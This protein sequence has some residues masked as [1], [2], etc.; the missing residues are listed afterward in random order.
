MKTAAEILDILIKRHC[1]AGVC[2]SCLQGPRKATTPWGQ[3]KPCAI[4]GA[5]G[6]GRQWSAFHA[7]IDVASVSPGDVVT[8]V[9]QHN[10]TAETHGVVDAMACDLAFDG[11]IAIQSSTAHTTR[12]FRQIEDGNRSVF[13]SGQYALALGSHAVNEPVAFN[14]FIKLRGKA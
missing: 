9:R 13:A 3:C 1:A 6:L 5:D 14:H 2:I 11:E 7:G 10:Y 4:A 8:W 12:S